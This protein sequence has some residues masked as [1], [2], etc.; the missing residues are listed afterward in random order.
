M[1]WLLVGI[2]KKREDQHRMTIR[3]RHA[4]QTQPIEPGINANRMP[5]ATTT[6]WPCATDSCVRRLINCRYHVVCAWCRVLLNCLLV[7]K[8]PNKSQVSAILLLLLIAFA[9]SGALDLMI[10]KA[11]MGRMRESNIEYLDKSFDKSV[12]GFLVLST[13]KAGLAIVEGSDIEFGFSLGAQGSIELQYG[14]VVQSMYDYVDVAWK[15]SLAGGAVLLLTKLL[16]NAIAQVDQWFL[17]V[18]LAS[19]FICHIV[20]CFLPRLKICSRGCRQVF[21]LFIVLSAV[22]YL[23]LPVT[24]FAAS[25]LSAR[26]SAPL[27]AEATE[28]YESIEDD[29]SSEALSERLSPFDAE[30][31]EDSGILSKMNVSERIR[32]LKKKYEETIEWMK[33]KMRDMAIW[34]IKLFA[35]Y[36][37]DC[38]VF[39]LAIFFVLFVATKGL[40]GYAFN[41]RRDKS[42]KEDFQ[43]IME[44]YY[45]KAAE[46]DND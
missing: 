24:V 9:V 44:R 42:F 3:C 43:S 20:D 31:E 18:A 40:L 41:L 25:S 2:G 7:M 15:T 19:L 37:F 6:G 29:L 46:K 22:L 33:G 32:R 17:V 34:T 30:Q 4:Q 28:G 27:I 21:S 35:G 12:K 5:Y 36:L 39:P 14:D 45:G 26:I 23:V 16:L 38:L 13:I 11:F 10:D 8:K 1:L